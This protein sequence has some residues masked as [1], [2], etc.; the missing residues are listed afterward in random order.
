[1]LV[2]FESYMFLPHDNMQ[3]SS[4]K[5]YFPQCLGLVST[6]CRVVDTSTEGERL[7]VCLWAGLGP[8]A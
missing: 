5:G 1:L 8:D 6:L 3:T 2:M 7:S 4:P